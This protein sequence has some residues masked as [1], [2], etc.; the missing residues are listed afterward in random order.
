MKDRKAYEKY[1]S[2]LKHDTISLVISA[3]NVRD[4]LRWFLPLVVKNIHKLEKLSFHCFTI[5]MKELKRI[6]V[7]SDS[8]KCLMFQQCNFPDARSLELAESLVGC[9]NRIQATQNIQVTRCTF[10]VTLNEF[11]QMVRKFYPEAEI[12]IEM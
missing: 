1:F 2:F 9:E 8:T 6:L 10:S 3:K 7:A 12:Q 5:S 4:R 11:E